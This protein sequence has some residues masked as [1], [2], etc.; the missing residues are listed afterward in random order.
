MPAIPRLESQD[1]QT[2]KVLLRSEITSKEWSKFRPLITARLVQGVVEIW[3]NGSGTGLHFVGRNPSSACLMDAMDSCPRNVDSLSC[4]WGCSRSRRCGERELLIP[5]IYYIC[6]YIYIY[7]YTYIDIY[8]YCAQEQKPLLCTR[9]LCTM[10][11]PLL[12]MLR[13]RGR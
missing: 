7:R 10:S 4:G 8:I 3:A 1:R 11:T 13:Y 6:I 9:V 5:Y 12:Q 2:Q